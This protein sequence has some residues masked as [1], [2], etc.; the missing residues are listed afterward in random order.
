MTTNE[1]L[2]RKRLEELALSA[3]N[4]EDFPVEVGP[5]GVERLFGMT[6]E[7]IKAL[8]KPATPELLEWAEKA[9]AEH[10]ER[11]GE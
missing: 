5:D 3:K 8:K 4:I 7:E 1:K 2:D 10:I 6:L 9:A 11:Y